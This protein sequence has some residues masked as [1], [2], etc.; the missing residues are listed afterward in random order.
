M[1]RKLS[2]TCVNRVVREAFYWTV[3]GAVDWAVWEAVHGAVNGTVYWAVDRAVDGA[4]DRSVNRAIRSQP[5]HPNLDLVIGEI[6]QA[7]ESVA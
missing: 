2:Y 4:V 5:P 1:V 3:D 7:R 6:Q